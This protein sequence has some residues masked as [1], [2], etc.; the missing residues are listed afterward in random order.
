MFY[1]DYTWDLNQDRIILD[2]QL[3]LA[4]LGWEDGDYFKLVIVNGRKQ[5]IKVDPLV[6][7]LKGGNPNG[8]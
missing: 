7:F 8:S 6:L 2:D 5:L 3:N 1:F 4:P